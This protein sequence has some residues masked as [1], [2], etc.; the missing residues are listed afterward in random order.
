MLSKKKS[1]SKVKMPGYS[2][3]ANVAANVKS[4]WQ[5]SITTI[6]KANGNTLAKSAVLTGSGKKTATTK[7]NYGTHFGSSL[8]A[9]SH[10]NPHQSHSTEPH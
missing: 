10:H 5:R 7:L 3:K 4:N 8:A 2:I 9:P 1:A 6:S